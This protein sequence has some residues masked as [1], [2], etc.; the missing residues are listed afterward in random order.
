VGDSRVG[1]GGGEKRKGE[2][3]HLHTVQVLQVHACVYIHIV[4]Y[5]LHML[6]KLNMHIIGGILII[7]KQHHCT[8]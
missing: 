4:Q 6:C 8:P 5:F 1:E 3:N 2:E 7:C